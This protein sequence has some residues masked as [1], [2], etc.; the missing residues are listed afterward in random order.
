MKSNQEGVI[1]QLG[2]EEVRNESGR[3][4][5]RGYDRAELVDFS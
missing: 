2:E 5:W 1:M 4:R 3:V